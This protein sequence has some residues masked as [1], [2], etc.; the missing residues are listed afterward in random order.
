M[1]HRTFTM[2]SQG[3]PMLTSLQTLDWRALLIAQ[4]LLLSTFAYKSHNLFCVWVCSVFLCNPSDT[5]I[6]EKQLPRQVY[7]EI[8]VSGWG[9]EARRVDTLPPELRWV[10]LDSKGIFSQTSF[11]TEPTAPVS[12]GN[13]GDSGLFPPTGVLWMGFTSLSSFPPNMS[14]L[15]VRCS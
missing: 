2:D 15:A 4:L 13:C 12:R 3:L 7:S 8:V 9:V 14:P 11:V 10:A 1:S 5:L 6:K